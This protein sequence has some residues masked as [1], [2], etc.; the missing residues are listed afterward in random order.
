M[1]FIRLEINYM[2][3]SS[4]DYGISREL[5]MVIADPQNQW[6]GNYAW[7]NICEHNLIWY[8]LRASKIEFTDDM[9]LNVS[10]S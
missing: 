5:Q 8:W 4:Y 6:Y 7:F 9:V 2:S 10:Y 1:I 3:L